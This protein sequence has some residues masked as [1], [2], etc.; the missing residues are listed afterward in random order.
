MEQNYVIVTVCIA[1][2]VGLHKQVALCGKEILSPAG[3]F[4]D[5]G[6]NACQS[7]VWAQW[8]SHAMYQLFLWQMDRRCVCCQTFFIIFWW[9]NVGY[10]INDISFVTRESNKVETFHHRHATLTTHSRILDFTTRRR[11]RRTINRRAARAS[12]SLECSTDLTLGRV[13]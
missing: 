13:R 12:L 10:G 4:R 3:V 9:K 7:L 6:D 2:E 5:S 1:R 11:P 8:P